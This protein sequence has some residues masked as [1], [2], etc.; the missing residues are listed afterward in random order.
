MGGR[1]GLRLVAACAV[2]SVSSIVAACAPPTGTAPGALGPQGGQ[3]LVGIRL[4]GAFD[5]ETSGPTLDDEV[6]VRRHDDGT[7]AGLSGT[8]EIPGRGAWPATVTF[9][10]TMTPL[11]VA[12]GSIDVE[13]PAAAIA[14]TTP[15]VF[16]PT[17][18]A[19]GGVSGTADGLRV[20]KLIDLLPYRLEWSVVDG[21]DEVAGAPV[22]PE[23][24]SGTIDVVTYNV[25]GL[26]EPLSGASPAT[27]SELI[28]PLLEPY[29]VALLQEDFFYADKIAQHITFPYGSKPQRLPLLSDSTRPSALVGSGLERYSRHPFTGY[30]QVRWPGCYGGIFPPGASDCLSQKG[31]SIARHEVAPGVWIDMYDLHAEAGST[32]DDVYWSAADYQDLAAYINTH[33][34]GHAVIVGGDF[35]LDRSDPVDGPILATFLTMTGLTDVCAVQDCSVEPDVIDRLLFRSGTDVAVTATAWSRPGGFVDAGGE[36]LSDHDPTAATFAWSVT[37]DD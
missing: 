25:A 32:P 21:D 20:W 30:E 14:L 15:L 1:V 4:T 22:L 31:F 23:A 2:A 16:A 29:D 9:D 28:S 8:V 36:P 18:T 35:N 10:V 7:F 26:P 37:A 17:T 13:D 33:S 34:V 11:G 19:A 6:A 3:Q 24:T 27:N 12:V 5:Y